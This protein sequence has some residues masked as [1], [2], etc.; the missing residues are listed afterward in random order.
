M[1]Y[2]V[3]IVMFPFPFHL[4]SLQY[5]QVLLK[6]NL[7]KTS[8]ELNEMPFSGPSVFHH[9]GICC[10]PSGWMGFPGGTS[11]KETAHQCRRHETWIQSLGREDPLE[12]GM[13]THSNTLAWENQGDWWATVHGVVKESRHD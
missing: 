8:H 4:P 6:S 3:I 1:V 11:G 12:E 9:L 10:G 5:I 2:M 7:R 13:A